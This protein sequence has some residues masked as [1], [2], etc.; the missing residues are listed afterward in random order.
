M[1]NLDPRVVADF[2]AEWR[3]FDQRG[4]DPHELQRLFDAYFAIFPWGRLPAHAEGFD[5]GCGSGRWAL[6]VA[7][8]VGKLHCVD[9][10]HEALDVARRTLAGCA[11]IEFHGVAID[12]MPM[13]DGS[14]DFGYSLG[15]LHH[16]PDTPRA[17]RDCVRKLK[18]GA[19][20]L[21]YLYYALDNRPAWFRALFRGVDF[22]RR[23]ISRLPSGPKYAVSQ[24]IAAFVYWPLARSASALEAVG[25]ATDR[26]P[27]SQYR[28]K[29]FYTMRTDALDRFGTRLEHRF[30]RDEVV[31]MMTDAGLR[32]VRVSERPPYWCAVGLKE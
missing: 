13:P 20:L 5:A 22:G 28:D 17:L 15:V 7:P 10:S 25:I 4:A 21:V 2:G 29:S 26:L 24:I 11:N 16:V 27:L 8:R 23:V 12:R 32:D 1:A 19:P 9:A 18:S 31:A 30:S 3:K 6:L 14:M